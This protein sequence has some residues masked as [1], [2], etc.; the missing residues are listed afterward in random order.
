[1]KLS[2][3]IPVYNTQNTLPRCMKSILGQTFSDY[4][5]ILVDDGSTD[6]SPQLCDEYARKDTRI[7]VIHKINGGL[8]DARNTGI[9]ESKG[10]YLTFMDSDD[11]I[12]PKPCNPS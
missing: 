1:M 12:A 7:S 4:E 6:R 3:V 9:A 2:I 5:I 10:E 8:S 11:A